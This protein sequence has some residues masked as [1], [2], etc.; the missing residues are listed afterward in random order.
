ME[1]PASE[2][3]PTSP[4]HATPSLQRRHTFA[5]RPYDV[6]VWGATGYT[7]TLICHRLATRQPAIRWAI[8]GRNQSKLEALSATL[9]MKHKLPQDQPDYIVADINNR[10]SMEVMAGRARCLLS[11]AGPYTHVGEPALRACL[12]TGTHYVDATAE[13]RWVER[14]L[15]SYGQTAKQK[16]LKLIPSCAFDFVPNDMM[17]HQ[18]N[19]YLRATNHVGN[20]E[21]S[22]HPREVTHVFAHTTPMVSGGTALS[23]MALMLSFHAKDVMDYYTAPFVMLNDEQRKF[24]DPEIQRAN[25]YT[26]LPTYVKEIEAYCVPF[27]MTN[28]MN[29]YVHWSNASQG[30][31][32]GKDLVYHGGEMRPNLFLAYLYSVIIWIQF[33]LVFALSRMPWTW[34]YLPQPGQG[35]Q[36]R[37]EKDYFKADLVA[38][39]PRIS[40]PSSSSDNDKRVHVS[41]KGRCD[42]GRER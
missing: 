9:R 4:T 18:L 23:G 30:F 33:F 29:K 7:G 6:V 32:W 19:K 24:I 40:P 20:K 1:T 2:A 11:V 17:L 8:A 26:I 13:T 27:V 28:L 16:Q 3:T 22:I 14:M 25:S 37:G 41:C 35:P 34:K 10:Q 12:D 15:I 5:V 36:L 39:V 38:S 31:V 21:Y 42:S